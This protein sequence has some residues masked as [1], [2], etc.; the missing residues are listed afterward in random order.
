MS[1]LILAED[2]LVKIADGTDKEISN[3]RT[4]DSIMSSDG[5]SITVAD[6]IKGKVNKI[7]IMTTKNNKKLRF[8]ED[9]TIESE[10][11]SV[12]ENNGLSIDEIMTTSGVEKISEIAK[13][14]YK[15]NVYSLRL[16]EDVF[17]IANE[18][19]VK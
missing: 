10:G 12:Y 8:A 5:Q 1:K 6:I 17:I 15:G 4:C 3:I 16:N 14:E 7:C 9:S 18:F 2:T 19:A 13:E 11:F